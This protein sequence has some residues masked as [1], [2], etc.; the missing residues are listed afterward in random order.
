MCPEYLTAIP[1]ISG[2][3][4]IFPFSALTLKA[5]LYIPSADLSGQLLLWYRLVKVFPVLLAS[6]TPSPPFVQANPLINPILSATILF[7]AISF[8]NLLALVG[9]Y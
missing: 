8:L 1:G 6:L 2:K 4:L 3:V 9:K 7:C 5:H